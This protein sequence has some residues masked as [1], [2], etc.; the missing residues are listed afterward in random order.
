M[1]DTDLHCVF[2]GYSD[3]EAGGAF[4]SGSLC[5]YICKYDRLVLAAA[6]SSCLDSRPALP[7]GA[8]FPLALGRLGALGVDAALQ[9]LSRSR[10]IFGAR[11]PRSTASPLCG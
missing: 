10:L 11:L 2:F 1:V 3:F 6:F 8:D 9:F 7:F 5:Q 4:L